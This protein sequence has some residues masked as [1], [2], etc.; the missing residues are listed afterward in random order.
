MFFIK[1]AKHQLV[2]VTKKISSHE[3]ITYSE[4][5]KVDFLNA[6]FRLSLLTIFPSIPFSVSSALVL[7]FSVILTECCT[8]AYLSCSAL[9]FCMEPSRTS[10]LPFTPAPVTFIV[11]ASFTPACPCSS[12]RNFASSFLQIPPR[13]GHPCSWLVVGNYKP[14]QWTFT[15]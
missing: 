15:T 2:I 9:S 1:M 10:W 4:Q 3:S 14:P 11:S 12:G 5:R 8:P 6:W 7:L 13:G